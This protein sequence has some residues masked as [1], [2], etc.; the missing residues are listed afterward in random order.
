MTDVWTKFSLAKIWRK[1][2]KRQKSFFSFSAV[3]W[4]EIEEKGE[5]FAVEMK[6]DGLQERKW[7]EENEW[8]RRIYH[9]W[10][11]VLS[12]SLSL[13]YVDGRRRTN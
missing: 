3:I 7:N 6:D 12:V 5:D 8:R 4:N 10:A 13:F 11:R 1:D 2:L 9:Y